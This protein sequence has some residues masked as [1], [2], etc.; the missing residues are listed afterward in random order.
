MTYAD[1]RYEILNMGIG[2]TKI[3]DGQVITRWSAEAWEVGTH[4]KYTADLTSTLSNLGHIRPEE[5]G[6]GAMVA[7]YQQETGCDWES[8]LV[9]C[10]CD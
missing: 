2:M 4:G 7:D 9:S 6:P 10:N 8:A 3:V 1:V 5:G